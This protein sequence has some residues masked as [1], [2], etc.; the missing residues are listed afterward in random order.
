MKAALVFRRPRSGMPECVNARADTGS[1]KTAEGAGGCHSALPQ[2]TLG[3][4]NLICL[5]VFKEVTKEGRSHLHFRERV[6]LE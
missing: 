6:W 5:K 2:Q 4:L 3:S 1:G